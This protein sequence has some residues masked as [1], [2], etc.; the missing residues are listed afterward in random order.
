MKKPF[1]FLTVFLFFG[2]LSAEEVQV[3]EDGPMIL[4]G[5]RWTEH[6]Y[7]PEKEPEPEPKETPEKKKEGPEDSANDPEPDKFYIQ[8]TLGTETGNVAFALVFNLDIDFLVARTK[9]KN[10]VSLGFDIGILYAPLDDF[11]TFPLQGNI[12]FDF[13]QKDKNLKY[14]SYWMSLGVDLTF[15]SYRESAGWLGASVAWRTGLSIV[16]TNNMVIKVGLDSSP[17]IRMY[18]DDRARGLYLSL[19]VALGY[20]F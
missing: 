3:Y 13:K 14:V 9:R 2:F 12:T 17:R 8:P 11:F 20:R 1:L 7:E 16:F 19:M 4:F 15:W 10:N 6:G 18:H 5:E